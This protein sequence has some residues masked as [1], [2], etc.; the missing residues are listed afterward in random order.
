M[1]NEIDEL[2]SSLENLK[3]KDSPLLHNIYDY[4]LLMV[5]LKEL[6]DMIEMY[7]VKK[8]VVSQI[9]FLMIN[10]IFDDEKDNFDGHM[11]HTV[12]C[13]PPGCGKS[14]MGIILAKIWTGLGLLK[15][16]ERNTEEEPSKVENLEQQIQNLKSSG[17]FKNEA[18][19]NL[20]NYIFEI[21]NNLKQID[22]KMILFKLKSL[23]REL[24]NKKFSYITCLKLIDDVLKEEEN[25]KNSI[26]DI[27]NNQ[28][29]EEKLQFTIQVSPL[30][31]IKTMDKII[32]EIKK[33][34]LKENI[35]IPTT[36]DD[37][38]PK[39]FNMIRIVSREDF[40]GGFLGQTAIKTEK[41]LRD[42][43]GKVL[44]IDEAYSLVNDEKD[45][46]GYECLTTLN[47]F[48]SEHPSEIVIIFAGYKDLLEQTI[49]KAQ[50][51]LKRRCTWH[52]EIENYSYNGLSEIFQKQMK[53]NGWS[54][55]PEVDI[56]SFFKDNYKEFPFFGG[57][58]L[59]LG[60]YCKICY[61]NYVFDTDYENTKIINE[62]ILNNALNYLKKYR[63][64]EP[65][66]SKNHHVMYL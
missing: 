2:I 44:F 4:K 52:F 16:V 42:S 14:Q 48:M 40:V 60:F 38:S 13:G 15:K 7:E 6:K 65:E 54:L 19:K 37:L 57:D 21:K 1:N 5:A 10:T 17:K 8:S 43:I 49:F 56:I 22:S 27:V 29:S 53:K 46:Y 61:S 35:F 18:V 30:K 36:N 32:K 64:K 63:I 31:D 47:R 9:K 58:T 34:P 50:P 20:Q 59:R 66:E 11:L 33:I 45:S 12:L 25:I 41:L 3:E 24:E 28:I 23:K 62:K 26:N 39:N 51:G 55:S